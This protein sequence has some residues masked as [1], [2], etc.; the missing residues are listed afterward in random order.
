M[1]V[2]GGLTAKKRDSLGGS[3]C[4]EEG[5]ARGRDDEGRELAGGEKHLQLERE[6]EK[7]TSR[8]CSVFKLEEDEAMC[9]WC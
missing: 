4:L 6:S 3:V 2:T 1:T 9:G 5:N 7:K 8:R